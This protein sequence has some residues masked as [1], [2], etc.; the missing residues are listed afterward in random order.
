MSP[1]IPP[2]KETVSLSFCIGGEP[3]AH[4]GHPHNMKLCYPDLTA[5]SMAQFTE[6]AEHKHHSK[7]PKKAA[8]SLSNSARR[9]IEIVLLL[10]V[11]VRLSQ[12]K[13]IGLAA[14]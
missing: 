6:S 4:T 10:D 5:F 12:S 7:R 9:E 13:A 3:T 14:H 8:I 1:K 2:D 11:R